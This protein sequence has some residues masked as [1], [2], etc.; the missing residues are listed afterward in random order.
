ME[1]WQLECRPRGNDNFLAADVGPGGE[2]VVVWNRPGLRFAERASA[3]RVEGAVRRYGIRG[4]N[5][6]EFRVEKVVVP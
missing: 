3:E 4:V 2:F 5:V 1:Y 6:D